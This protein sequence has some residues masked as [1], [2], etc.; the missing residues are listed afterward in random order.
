MTRVIGPWSTRA[1]SL[2]TEGVAVVASSAAL[3]ALVGVLEDRGHDVVAPVVRHGSWVLGHVGAADRLPVGV[4][5]EQAPGRSRLTHDRG[6]RSFDSAPTP[7]WTPLLHPPE[8]DL[9]VLHRSSGEPLVSGPTAPG[10]PLALFG[11][12]ACDVRAIEILDRVLA[13][14]G[15]GDPDWLARRRDL[16]VVAVTCAVPASTCW[17]TSTGGGP[18]P[19]RFDIRLTELDDVT[20]PTGQREEPLLLIEIGSP[21]GESIVEELD[22][23]V[24]LEPARDE[25]LAAAR[26]IVDAAVAAMAARVEPATLHADEIEEHPYWDEVAERCVACGNCT[27]VCPTCF[28][29][30]ILDHTALGDDRVVRRR[31]WASC[32]EL[33]HSVVGGQVVR[34]SRAARYRQWL[35]HKL[36]TWGDQFGTPGCVGCGRCSIACPVGI[37]LPHEASMLTTARRSGRSHVPENGGAP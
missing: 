11:V 2:H 25:H 9:V 23:V 37:D 20:G 29:V 7:P 10:R 17:C 1:A 26:R 30:S 13:A 12:R 21:V 3:A 6:R 31:T 8:V 14:G 24:D 22:E 36:V 4:G 16:V 5:V 15:G 33:D 34:A 32:F 19:H 28:C 18:S 35:M 27:S